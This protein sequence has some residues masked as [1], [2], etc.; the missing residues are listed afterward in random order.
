MENRSPRGVSRRP[1][2]WHAREVRIAT[3]NLW[4]K[5]GPWEARAEPIAIELERVDA[6][7]VGLQEVWSDDEADQARQLGDHLGLHVARTTRPSGTPD[8][9]GNALLSRWPITS[10]E[11]IRLPGREGERAVRSVLIAE[12]AHPTGAQVVAVTHLAWQYDRS[13]LREA[14]LALVA[15]QLAARHDHSARPPI[16]VGDLNAEPEADEVRR[17]TG[18]AK[19]YVDGLVFTDAWAAVGDGEGHTW[20]RDN[21]HSANAQWPRRRLDHV[22]IAWPRPKPLGNPLRAELFGVDPIGGVVPS[23]HYGVVVETDERATVET[24]AV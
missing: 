23:D 19:A 18:R 5:F 3:W 2:S 7:V 4:W 6:D 22:M 1:G 11:T 12:I 10:S 9:F 14:Q 15:E 20:T 8:G 16:L 21:P 13:A 24:G 17:L